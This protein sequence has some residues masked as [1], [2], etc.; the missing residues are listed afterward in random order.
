MLQYI[1]SLYKKNQ[2]K[3]RDDKRNIVDNA[4]AGQIVQVN[5]GN[6]RYYKVEKLV[7]QEL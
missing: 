2:G 6:G 5:Y 3:E 4:L 7:Y 1:D